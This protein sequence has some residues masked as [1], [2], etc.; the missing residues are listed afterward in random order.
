MAEYNVQVLVDEIVGVQPGYSIRVFPER[1]TLDGR[2]NNTIVWSMLLPSVG[3][4]ESREDIEFIT[5]GGKQRFP[6]PRFEDGRITVTVS[7][8]EE[9]ETIYNYALTV[10][11]GEGTNARMIRIDPEVDNPPPPPTGPPPNPGP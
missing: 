2:E 5:N 11:V 1:L 6:D 10:H 7:C 8:L 3:R 9:N 4:F